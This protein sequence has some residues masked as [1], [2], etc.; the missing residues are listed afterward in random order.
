MAK[1]KVK[2][3]SSYWRIIEQEDGE[4]FIFNDSKFR[5]YS[6]KYEEIEDYLAEWVNPNDVMTFVGFREEDVQV[7][8]KK[9]LKEY[10]AK[11]NS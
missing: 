6:R 10:H 4:I 2:T 11:I 1:K 8:G 5:I 3:S 9:F 7:K